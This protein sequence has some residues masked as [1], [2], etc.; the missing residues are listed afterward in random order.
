MPSD[1]DAPSDDFDAMLD[2]DGL[3]AIDSLDFPSSLVVP[4]DG[5]GLD[6]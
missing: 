5:N 2:A 1:L 3:M 6:P 4:T